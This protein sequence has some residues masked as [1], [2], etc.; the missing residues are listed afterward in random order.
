MSDPLDP[1]HPPTAL[2]PALLLGSMHAVV[3]GS[4]AAL[5]AHLGLLPTI[6]PETLW[7]MYFVYNLLAFGIQFVLGVGADRRGLYR[8]LAVGGLVAVLAGVALG[9]LPSATWAAIVVAGLGNA[10]F[11]VGAGAIILQRSPDRAAATGVLVAPGALGLAVGQWAA[12]G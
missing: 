4:C 5:V 12:T 10:A 11:H 6:S 9:T 1:Y 3:D 2:R 8:Q 7:L